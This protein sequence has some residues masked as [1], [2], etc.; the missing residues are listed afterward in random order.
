MR[1]FERD[2]Y[3]MTWKLKYEDIQFSKNKAQ[4]SVVSIFKET[5]CG[6]D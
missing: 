1:K 3:S 4:G 2:V 5:Y 6:V